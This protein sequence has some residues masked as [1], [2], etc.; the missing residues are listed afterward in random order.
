MLIMAFIMIP[1]LK[2][3]IVE[4][5]VETNPMQPFVPFKVGMRVTRGINQHTVS[6]NMLGRNELEK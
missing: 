6:N 5:V 3:D 1:T 2:I 4:N